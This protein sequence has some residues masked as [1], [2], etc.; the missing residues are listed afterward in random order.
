MTVKTKATN[1]IE[2]LEVDNPR[3]ADLASSDI[4]RLYVMT[5][6][7][8]VGRSPAAAAET[9][10]RYWLNA[11]VSKELSAAPCVCAAGIMG[12]R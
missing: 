6:N 2:F 4:N 1:R 7:E 5:L 9:R 11:S 8:A 12:E 10:A 3:L